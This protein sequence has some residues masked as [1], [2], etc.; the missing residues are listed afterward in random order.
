MGAFIYEE[1]FSRTEKSDKPE[2]HYVI[3]FLNGYHN[4]A[5]SSR[6]CS[7]IRSCD[8][9]YIKQEVKKLRAR[10]ETSL[11]GRIP[12]CLDERKEFIFNEP[13]KKIKNIVIVRKGL[14]LTSLLR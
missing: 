14:N 3:S 2:V 10:G 1:T 6:G 12:P 13:S 9:E 7:E 11:F 4:N 5:S 8:L